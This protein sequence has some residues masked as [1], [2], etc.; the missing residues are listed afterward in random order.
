MVLET[1]NRMDNPQST[2]FPYKSFGTSPKHKTQ[3]A[4]TKMIKLLPMTFPNHG[5]TSLLS[6]YLK[7]YLKPNF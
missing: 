6:P 4:Q 2:L 7:Q 3:K 5:N 1:F